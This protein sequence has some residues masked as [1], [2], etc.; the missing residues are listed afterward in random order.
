VHLLGQR[1][2]AVDWLSAADV[3]VL[4]SLAEGMPL[5]VMEAMAKGLPVMATA[6]SGVPEELG[7]TGRLLPDPKRA[8]EALMRVLVAAIEAWAASAELRRSLG[9]AC[10]ERARVMFREERML[11]ETR[12]VIERA[13]ATSNR[14][15]RA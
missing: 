9:A 14:V 10:Q 6:V 2:D 5:A 7:T 15:G 3:F 1:R 12:A 4:T 13:L 8:P 11:A